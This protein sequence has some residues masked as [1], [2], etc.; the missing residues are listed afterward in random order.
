MK[1]TLGTKFSGPTQRKGKVGLLKKGAG[2]D[3]VPHSEGI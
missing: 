1:Y 3:L 2:R